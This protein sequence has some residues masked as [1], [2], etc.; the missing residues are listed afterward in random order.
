MKRNIKTKLFRQNVLALHSGITEPDLVSFILCPNI[1]YFNSS[2]QNKIIFGYYIE[3]NSSIDERY[4]GLCFEQLIQ[5]FKGDLV[6]H[7]EENV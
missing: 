6:I 5:I 4:Y 3:D 7:N 1:H 2:N